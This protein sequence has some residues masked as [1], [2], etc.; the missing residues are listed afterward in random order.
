METIFK[1][2]SLNFMFNV[3]TW[4]LTNQLWPLDWWDQHFCF[5]DSSKQSKNKYKFLEN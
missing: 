3:N 1:N 4:I 5:Y 2:Y